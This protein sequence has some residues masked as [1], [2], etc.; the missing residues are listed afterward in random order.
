MEK[1]LENLEISEEIKTELIESFN[2]A[3]LVESVNMI[4]EKSK[5]Y[6]EYLEETISEK[7]GAYTKVM[8]E[9]KDNIEEKIDLYLE[10]VVEEFMEENTFTIEESIKVQKSETLIEGFDALLVAAGVELAEIVEGVEENREENIIESKEDTI[11]NLVEEISDLKKSNAEMLKLG[12]IKESME[13]LTELQKEKFMNLASVVEFNVNEANTYIEKLD[14][15][16]KSVKTKSQEVTS[17]V[18]EKVEAK[19]INENTKYVSKV[20]HLYK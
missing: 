19:L 14:L 13:Y 1:I 3:V 2:E 4:A 16:A 20:S 11:D 7:D 5:E 9:Y 18:V 10:R 8:E 17:R 15:I 12:L 6:E